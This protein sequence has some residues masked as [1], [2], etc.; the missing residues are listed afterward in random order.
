ME[1]IYDDILNVNV[2][3]IVNAA[4]G[5]GF[6]GGILGKY[7]KFNGLA[8]YL[9]YKSNGNI[10]KEAKKECKKNKKMPRFPFNH[11]KKGDIFE[12]NSYL[13]NCN[14]IYH[15]IT[16]TYPGTKSS[17]K[18]ITILCDKILEL[19]EKENIKSI[20]IPLLGCG[21]GGLKKDKILDIYNE[22]FQNYEKVKIIIVRR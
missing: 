11:L 14:K 17:Y 5:V 19:V 22:K 8:E 1:V 18:I 2:D 16:M 6:M 9:N 13:H 10:E 15:A 20:A 12:T 3:V 4:N 21:V 7:I